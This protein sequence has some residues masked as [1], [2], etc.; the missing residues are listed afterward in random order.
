MF[1]LI[2]DMAE[3]SKSGVMEVYMR[4]TGR[5]TKQTEEED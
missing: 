3:D 5:M 4:D 1:T 2:K